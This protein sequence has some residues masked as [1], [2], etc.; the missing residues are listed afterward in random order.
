L[1][2]TEFLTV[3]TFK[4]ALFSVLNL[5][6]EPHTVKGTALCLRARSGVSEVYA[7]REPDEVAPGSILLRGAACP[8]GTFRIGGGGG[9]FPGNPPRDRPHPYL[10]TSSSSGTISDPYP[11][12]W[13][14][15][16]DNRFTNAK[17]AQVR[18]LATC[19]TARAL[20]TWLPQDQLA[21]GVLTQANSRVE[22]FVPC[23]SGGEIAAGGFSLP[24]S[25]SLLLES[26]QPSVVDGTEG[27]TV[28]VLN[29]TPQEERFSALAVCLVAS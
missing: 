19:A 23:P 16:V 29:P 27:W 12:G 9:V 28:S 3:P 10:L 11:G 20:R 13:T 4:M 17:P 2:S 6:N 26:S 15:V 24:A 8:G 22:Q 5:D 7:W 21:L 18:A 14:I 1:L 25:G